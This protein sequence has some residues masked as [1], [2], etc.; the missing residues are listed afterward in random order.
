MW[1]RPYQLGFSLCALYN[2][3]GFYLLHSLKGE[4]CIDFGTQTAEAAERKG[5]RLSRQRDSQTVRQS[6]R[7]LEIYGQILSEIACAY[8]HLIEAARRR[9]RRR[10]GARELCVPLELLMISQLWRRSRKY[11]AYSTSSAPWMTEWKIA[12]DNRRRI[13]FNFTTIAAATRKQPQQQQQKKPFL[14]CSVLCHKELS[15]LRDAG[16]TDDRRKDKW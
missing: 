6:G 11:T 7:D 15:K 8:N 1:D 10:D 4:L 5:E 9:R 12:W 13:Q 2:R 16:A 3:D 14:C